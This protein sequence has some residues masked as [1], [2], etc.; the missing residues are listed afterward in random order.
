MKR[1]NGLSLL[2]IISMCGIIG[3]HLINNG[4][5]I[6]NLNLYSFKF[7]CILIV[8]TFFYTSVNVFALLTGYL[9]VNK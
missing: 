9:N 4:G 8:T 7:F 2:R 6:N 5:V 1:N 3:L